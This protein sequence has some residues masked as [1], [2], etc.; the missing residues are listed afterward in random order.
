MNGRMS[1]ELNGRTALVTGASS[2]LGAHFAR[3]LAHNGALVALAARRTDRLEAL[4]AE[5]EGNGGRAAAIAIDV[6]D[7]ASVEAALDAAEAELGPLRV[8]V[9]NAGVPSEGRAVDVSDEQWRDVMAVNLD[10][11]FRTAR[12]AAK[13]MQAHREGG[14]IINI[15]SILGLGVLRGLA[16]Y[17]TS[18]AAVIQLTKALAVELARDNIRVNA[19]APGYFSTEIN[20]GFLESDAGQ[21]LMSRVPMRR[22]GNLE[23]LNGPLML[24]ASDAG[25]F[26]TG[27][28]ITVD[29]GHALSMG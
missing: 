8:I 17:A 23:D 13:R 5:I 12:G 15:A 3:T 16:P 7:G 2:G 14:S 18:K 26:M 28:V 25:A 20:A 21:H 19:L 24:L 10:G 1:L 9:N 4:K 22:F 27:S 6:T 11:V 29:G